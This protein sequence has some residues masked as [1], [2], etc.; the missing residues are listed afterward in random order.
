[1]PDRSLTCS[2]RGHLHWL[3]NLRGF[4]DFPENSTFCRAWAPASWTGKPWGLFRVKE[5]RVHE[6]MADLADLRVGN[7]VAVSRLD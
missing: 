7:A 3:P 4:R 1:M 6:F 2:K 5:R